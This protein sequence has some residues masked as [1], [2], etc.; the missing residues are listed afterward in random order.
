M[1]TIEQVKA[2]ADAKAAADAAKAEL[3]ERKKVFE[4]MNSELIQAEKTLKANVITLAAG[5]RADA[6]KEYADNGTKKFPG[7]IGVRLSS[8]LEYDAAM[9]EEWARSKDLFMVLDVDAFEAAAAGLNLDFVSVVS[10][11]T[12]TIP[13]K[14]K[15]DE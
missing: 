9:A 7:G 6:A 5:L 1:I 8:S 11:P 2:Y 4:V 13:A 14:V 10:K 3:T 12:I 15:I